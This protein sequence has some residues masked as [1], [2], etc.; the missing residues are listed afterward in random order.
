MHLVDRP[1]KRPK[2]SIYL[3]NIRLCAKCKGGSR[4]EESHEGQASDSLQ[5]YKPCKP[6]FFVHRHQESQTNSEEL[7][8]NTG[9]IMR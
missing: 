6:I 4:S 5:E 3:K 8:L 2:N 1:H 9:I 7:L